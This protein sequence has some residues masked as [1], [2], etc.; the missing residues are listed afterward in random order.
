MLTR[1][2][3]YVPNRKKFT[4]S[5]GEDRFLA[6]IKAPESVNRRQV[7]EVSL[8][9][10]QSEIATDWIAA[11]KKYVPPNDEFKVKGGWD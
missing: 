10:A 2:F 9:D 3:I 5:N 6:S 1:K 8:Q 4:R 7:F 11:Y